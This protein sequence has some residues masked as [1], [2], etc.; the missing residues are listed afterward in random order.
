MN[1]SIGSDL[2]GLWGL[3]PIEILRNKNYREMVSNPRI[4]INNFL[5]KD[6]P[7]RIT[8]LDII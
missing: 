6:H 8:L 3:E 5:L 7:R 1:V 2:V 4:I